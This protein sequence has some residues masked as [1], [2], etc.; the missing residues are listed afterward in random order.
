MTPESPLWSSLDD[1][2]CPGNPARMV[3]CRCEVHRPDLYW[4]NTNA[5]TI[6]PGTTSGMVVIERAGGY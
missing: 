1:R 5:T 4:P 6:T 2:D 3:G